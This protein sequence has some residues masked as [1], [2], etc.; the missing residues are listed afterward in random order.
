MNWGD[1]WWIYMCMTMINAV[2]G[3]QPFWW[4]LT[5]YS[6]AMIFILDSID[7]K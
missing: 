1:R 3:D 4:F 7:K 6:I 5:F 2:V